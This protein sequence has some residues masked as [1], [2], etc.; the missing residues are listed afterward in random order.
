MDR[1]TSLRSAIIATAIALSLA[2]CASSTPESG[3]TT[4]PTDAAVATRTVAHALGT[5]EIPVD[6]QRILVLD[7]AY[8]LDNLVA[9]GLGDSIVGRVDLNGV[10]DAEPSWLTD[11]I[12]FDEV[13]FL[14]S[15]YPD[16]LDLEKVAVLQPDLIIGIGAAF[17]DQYE[18]ISKIAP[19]VAPVAAFD[20]VVGDWH[21]VTRATA[22]LLDREAEGEAAIAAA[23][24]HLQE[25][26]D[27][28][29]DGLID[30]TVVTL[31][32]WTGDPTLYF[33]AS[34]DV[35]SLFADAGF[36]LNPGFGD[37]TYELLTP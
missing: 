22:T 4:S 26:V 12:D 6:P 27:S 19:S 32:G 31:G 18:E 20:L 7:S 37:S 9:L 1:L 34:P 15:L 2:G 36:E 8:I 29:P 30:R 21:D 5:T 13:E 17:G 16:G 33:S 25:R 28:A 11:E 35:T 23:D 10:G 14:G 3:S 24:A